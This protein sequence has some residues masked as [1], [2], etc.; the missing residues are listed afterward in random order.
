MSWTGDSSFLGA[1]D[2]PLT[3]TPTVPVMA[4]KEKNSAAALP[5]PRRSFETSYGS[6]TGQEN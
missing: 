4:T 1:N 5:D 3:A 6:G 2:W